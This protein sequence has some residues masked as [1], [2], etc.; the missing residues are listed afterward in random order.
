MNEHRQNELKKAEE[1]HQYAI[2]A[3]LLMTCINALLGVLMV[4]EIFSI[5][6]GM[7]LSFAAMV[8][9]IVRAHR[10]LLDPGEKIWESPEKFH[11]RR[12][13]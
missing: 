10:D 2:T 8:I 5:P 1:K 9:I 12:N 11:Q 7:G 6:I 4:T 3:L 13:R